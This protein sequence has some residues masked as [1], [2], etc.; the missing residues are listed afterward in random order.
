MSTNTQP[1]DRFL[2]DVT[3]DPETGHQ[4]LASD[5]VT[6]ADSAGKLAR[7][8]QWPPTKKIWS[9]QIDPVTLPQAVARIEGWIASEQAHCRFVVTPNVDHVVQLYRRPELRWIYKN[10]GLTLADGWPLVTMSRVYGK[11]LPQRVAGSDLV[12]TLFEGFQQRSKPLKVYLLGGMTGVPQ[13]AACQIQTSWPWVKVVGTCSPPLGFER[14]SSRNEA[15]VDSINSSQADVLV[16]GLGFPKQEIWMDQHADKITV[17]VALCVGATIDFLAGEQTRAPRW[18]QRFK[19]EWL[20]RLAT[21]PKRLASRY[22]LDAVYFP[23]LCVKEFFESLNEHE[24]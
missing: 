19:L 14:D 21:N 1:I 4:G 18:M 16:I 22:A 11:S 23:F 10:A 9:I 13:R 12:P 17:P 3:Q 5:C 15:I 2:T 7:S 8:T 20:H 6:C 24:Q